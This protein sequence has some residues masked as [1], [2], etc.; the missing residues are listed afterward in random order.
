MNLKILFSFLLVT[1][2]GAGLTFAQDTI[3]ELP[4]GGGG[5]L[6]LPTDAESLIS[7]TALIIGQAMSLILWLQSKFAPKWLPIGNT[8]IRFIVVGVIVSA[9]TIFF[10]WQNG[11]Q[12]VGAFLLS[13]V[14]YDKIWEPLGLKTPK[15]PAITSVNSEEK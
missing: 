7:A 9:V 2:F 15:L 3:P 1:V 6:G 5:F 4:P 13:A 10:G 11:W 14:T 8:K 12:A